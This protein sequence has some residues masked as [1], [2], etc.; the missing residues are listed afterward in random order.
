MRT[1]SKEIVPDWQSAASA[2]I[3]AVGSTY[4]QIVLDVLKDLFQPGSVPH[5]FVVKTMGDFATSNGSRGDRGKK[6][7]DEIT[8]REPF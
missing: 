6:I 2:V 1:L 4:G 8:S 5:Y 7:K 3:V